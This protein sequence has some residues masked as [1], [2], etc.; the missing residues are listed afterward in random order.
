MGSQEIH[1]GHTQENTRPSPSANGLATSL[2][3]SR[4]SRTWT[5]ISRLMLP[6]SRDDNGKTVRCVGEH[7]TLLK[8][9]EEQ[10][11]LTIHCKFAYKMARLSCIDAF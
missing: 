5:S 7:P 3:L 10:T 8:P 2:G 6:V 4:T 11:F 9:M 1:T